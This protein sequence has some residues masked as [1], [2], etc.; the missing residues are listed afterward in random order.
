[1]P[2]RAT[3]FPVPLNVVAVLAFLLASPVHLERPATPTSITVP[4]VR[5]TLARA[6]V[7]IFGAAPS[8]SRLALLV[9]QV[10]L[11]G[12]ALPGR[13]LGGLEYIAGRPWVR[14]DRLTRLQAFDDY[15][16]AA[17]AYVR[18]LR[19]RCVNYTTSRASRS[20]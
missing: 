10:R 17:R 13:N 2:H 8:R 4:E 1:M 5:A 16:A 12:L 11:E 19:S 18:L 15:D 20:P 7:D 14:V 6:H 9:A 3:A